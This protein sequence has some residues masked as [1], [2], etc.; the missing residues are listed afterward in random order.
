MQPRTFRTAF[1]EIKT[2][3]SRPG[4]KL[5]FFTHVGTPFSASVFAL[6]WECRT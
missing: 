4:T 2:V 1:G 6:M 3:W 5:G